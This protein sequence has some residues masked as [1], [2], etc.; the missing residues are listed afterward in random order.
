MVLD[1]LPLASGSWNQGEQCDAV[2]GFSEVGVA[3]GGGRE[4]PLVQI[5][6]NRTSVGEA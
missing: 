1:S 2:S 5:H 3:G 4:T 6:I